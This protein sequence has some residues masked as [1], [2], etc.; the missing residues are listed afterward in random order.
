MSPVQVVPKKTGIIVIKNDKN[1]LIT[2]RIQSEWRICNDYRKLSFITRKDHFPL[3]F[4]DQMFERLAER[5]FY[6]FLD[7]YFNYAQVLIDPEN[8]EKTTFVCHFCSYD[9]RKMPF[10]LCDSLATSQTCM[11]LIFFDLV[12][13]CLEVF[14]NDFS[15]YGHSFNDCSINLGKVLRTY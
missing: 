5:A 13:Q 15:A 1:E 12:E 11:I 4:L 8:K 7:G 6:A 9:F 2:T 14:M 10:G 3:P